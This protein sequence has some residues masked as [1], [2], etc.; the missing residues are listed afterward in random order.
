ML[1]KGW[2]KLFG[3]IIT[4][5]IWCEDDKT[6]IMW[7]TM[8]AMADAE[9]HVSGTIPGMAKVAKMSLEDAEKAIKKLS[10]PDKYSRSTEYDGRRIA[11]S[12]DGFGG[13]QILNYLKYR[14]VRD[15]VKRREQI[16]KA[17]AKYREKH[18]NS[19]NSLNSNQNSNQSN[20][21][22][23]HTDTDTDTEKEKR[24]VNQKTKEK[25][26]VIHSN[27]NVTHNKDSLK[28]ESRK[29]CDM[30][31]PMTPEERREYLRNAIAAKKA[32]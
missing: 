10:E 4:S 3:N 6:R 31:P 14:S 19:P 12:E 18:R 7:I 23:S 30:P 22:S 11:E 26:S 20:P 29:D 5:S 13:W 21:K 27:P 8:L 28:E 9:G 15:P 17:Q 25:D 32:G 16:R 24:K 1:D 2:T